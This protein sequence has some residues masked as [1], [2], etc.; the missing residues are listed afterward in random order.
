[1]SVSGE[2][3]ITFPRQVDA[4][5]WKVAFLSSSRENAGD[6]RILPTTDKDMEG[7]RLVGYE[8]GEGRRGVASFNHLWVVSV[9]LIPPMI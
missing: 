4:L 2:R 3:L 5:V 8:K 1:M 6:V 7:S 9:L